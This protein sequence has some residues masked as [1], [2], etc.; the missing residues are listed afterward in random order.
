[1]PRAVDRI[2]SVLY[3]SV[4][5]IDYAGGEELRWSL[6][7]AIY[8]RKVAVDGQTSPWTCPAA[9]SEAISGCYVESGSREPLV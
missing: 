1:M 6:S 5:I 4:E 7:F 9:I 3:P 2:P 8:M